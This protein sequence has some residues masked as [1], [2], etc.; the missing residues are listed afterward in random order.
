MIDSNFVELE[1]GSIINLNDIRKIV[2]TLS[3]HKDYKNKYFVC[4]KYY[5]DD[6]LITVDEYQFIKELLQKLSNSYQI[7]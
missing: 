2:P 1:N 7:V 3:S 4:F 6:C 5:D